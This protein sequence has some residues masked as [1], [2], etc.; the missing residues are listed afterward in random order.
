MMLQSLGA[1][2]AFPLKTPDVVA[3][4]P[5]TKK[6]GFYEVKLDEDGVR[7]GQI[8]SLG[9]LSHVL[10]ADVAVVRLEPSG[11]VRA[12]RQHSYEFELAE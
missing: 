10:G 6:W 1:R 8:Q 9:L 5:T 2:V 7:L 4:H 11:K 3:F 12:L